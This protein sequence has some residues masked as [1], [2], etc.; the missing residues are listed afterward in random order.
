MKKRK[1]KIVLI[2]AIIL[3]LNT[4]SFVN[5]VYASNIDS[6]YIHSIGDCG[7]LL[8]YKGI[9]VK[10]TY[11][12]YT[13]DGVSY[14]AY[15]MDKTKIG[16]E[17]NAYNVSV[18]DYIKDIKLWRI[19]INGYPY[20]SIQELGVANKEEA[21]VATKQAVYC[22]IHGNNLSDYAAIG[23]AGERTLNA[24]KKIITNAQNSNESKIS[25]T[26]KI[27]KNLTQWKQDNIDKNYLSKTYNITAGA[28]IKNY[29]ITLAKEK[30]EDIGGI[31][32]T[33][34]KNR[35]KTEFSPNEKFKILIPIK[36]M[37]EAGK[38][39]LKVETKI[40]TKPILYGAAPNSSM[41]D[42]ALTAATYE[43]GIGNI[44]DEYFKNETKIVI[45][46]LDENTKEKIEGVEFELLDENKKVVYSDLKTDKEGKINLENIVPGTYYIRETNAKDGYLKYDDLI[47]IDIKLNEKM[48]VTINNNK[49]EKPKIETSTKEI[50]VSQE[51]INSKSENKMETAKE[52]IKQI[53][54]LPVTGM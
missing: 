50:E 25:S 29:K 13:K 26:I 31:K 49:E 8:T 47:K 12:Q 42:Y 48:T 2:L 39:E 34:E 6:A 46:K 1:M 17:T 28:N 30:G 18:Q 5:S 41:Q 10:V 36:N 43:D 15:C 16:A 14:P 52:N 35:E 32:L 24:M 53:K 44:Q 54:K 11:V 51:V 33:D 19:I 3:I 20:K 27:N 7:K 22:Y 45:I 38:F 9:V 4:L 21:F 37:K 23:E 40:N